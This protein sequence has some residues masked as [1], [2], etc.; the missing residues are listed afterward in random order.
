[1]IPPS[2]INPDR[3]RQAVAMHLNTNE[4]A[5]YCGVTV[6]HLRRYLRRLAGPRLRPSRAQKQRWIEAI[7]KHKARLIARMNAPAKPKKKRG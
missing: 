6:P 1:M 4:T 2:T 7:E 3:L 5:A